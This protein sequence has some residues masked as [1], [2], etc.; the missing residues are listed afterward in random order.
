ML[1]AAPGAHTGREGNLLWSVSVHTGEQWGCHQPL[2]GSRAGSTQTPVHTHACSPDRTCVW[3]ESLPGRPAPV[4]ASGCLLVCGPCPPVPLWSLLLDAALMTGLL[5]GRGP[6]SHLTGQPLQRTRLAAQFCLAQSGGKVVFPLLGA[7]V[8][9]SLLNKW[10]L[11]SC[12]PLL[13][14]GGRLGPK[15]RL[16]GQ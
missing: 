4:L 11:R 1:G 8:R 2:A 9:K 13:L 12:V 7:P 5:W 10:D 3:P 6:L 16:W 14:M 15:P